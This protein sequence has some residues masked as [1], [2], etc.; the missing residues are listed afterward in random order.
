[1]FQWGR[2]GARNSRAEVTFARHAALVSACAVGLFSTGIMRTLCWP[3]VLHEVRLSANCPPSFE[4]VQGICEF[5]SLYDLYTAGP[6]AAGLRVQL[7]P[8]QGRFTPQQI[9]LGRYLFFDPLLSS[10][11]QLSC[12][13]CHQPSR[14]FADGRGRSR[15]SHGTLLARGAPPLWNVG[16]L[17]NL[18][19]DGSAH[20]LTQQARGPLFS[21]DEMA[22]TEQ[23][24]E[25]ELNQ[26]AAYSA[27]FAEAFQLRSKG[28]I[29]VNLL[30]RALAA[31]ESTLISFNSRYDRY[32][33]GDANALNAQERR[34]F[35]LFRGVTLACSQCHTPPLFTN[36][37]IEVTGVP[38]APGMAFDAGAGTTTRDRAHRGAFRT[39]SLRNVAQTSPYMHAGQ[40][41]SLRDVV[42]FYN[43]RAGHAAP[44]EE[45][46][47][48]DWR[49]IL[50]RPL[51]SDDEVDA[52]VAF[53]R[54]LIDESMMPAI[55]RQVP[56]G[57]P[58]VG[59]KI[60]GPGL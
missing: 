56:S 59:A 16:F 57:F 41:E 27:L 30:A 14:S 40:F 19:W 33:H 22:N 3:A 39:P 2:K 58:V 38:N 45:D 10:D 28:R 9:D 20:S 25:R 53:L 8:L 49:M 54:T 26:N 23:Q 11:H 1:L 47:Q 29:T 60:R 31:F 17:N 44:R 50:A 4:L 21:P 42:R 5:R 35:E 52:V 46:L 15:N 37:E 13:S 12:A 32:A 36:D 18:R 24:L 55:P 48:I 34:G 7:P 43:D 51:L 6:G